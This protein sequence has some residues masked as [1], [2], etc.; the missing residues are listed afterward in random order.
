MILAI[1]QLAT[2]IN[3]S[4]GSNPSFT[5]SDLLDYTFDTVYGSGTSTTGFNIDLTAQ[6][7]TY[8]GIAG[9]NLGSLGCTISIIN[10]DTTDITSFA[11]SDDRPIMFVIPERT[12]GTNNFVRIEITKP[13]SADVAIISHVATGLTTDFTSTTVN[14]QEIIKSYQAGYNK[15]PMNRGI[16][17]R[18]VLNESAAPTATLIQTVSQKLNLNIKDVATS[19][20][21]NELVEYQ[22][23]WT[24]NGFFMR[25]D[26]DV[27]QT[28]VAM[29]F[30]PIM[31]KAHAQ[32]RNLT[33][34]S[35]NFLAYNGL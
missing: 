13:N 19:F 1:S 12:G 25:N 4:T 32:T 15:V 24:L 16:K 23:F 5:A 20:V 7:T 28:Y 29:Q 14:G 18:A 26:D 22:L 27:T 8:V 21:Q 34:V 9:H 17:S 10:H 31:P 33:N 2:A 30:I 35:Y 3:V 6:N 11:P